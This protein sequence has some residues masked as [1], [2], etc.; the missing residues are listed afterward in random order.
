MFPLQL[1]GKGAALSLFAFYRYFSVYDIH[2]TL[3]KG[4]SQT[5]ALSAVGGVSLIEFIKDTCA[6]LGGYS[7]ACIGYFYPCIAF[8]GVYL[9]AYPSALVGE[10]KGI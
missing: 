4:K 5:V 9:S 10:F 7:A 6:L 3:Y 1:Y 2:N 8:V